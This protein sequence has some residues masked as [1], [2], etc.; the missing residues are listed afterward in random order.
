MF[1]QAN[2]LLIQILNDIRGVRTMIDLKEF[3]TEKSNEFN[4]TPCNSPEDYAMV[5]SINKEMEVVRREFQT[6][7]ETSSQLCANFR[8][9]RC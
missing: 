3:F 8:F 2:L 5:E 4:W 7:V 9:S 1:R 6:K